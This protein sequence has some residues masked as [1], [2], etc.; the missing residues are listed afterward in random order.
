MTTALLAESVDTPALL[1]DLPRLRR[2]IQG[3]ASI[4][5]AAGINLRPHV[6]THKTLEIARLQREAGAVGLTV[7]KLAEAEV[8]ADAGFDDIFVAYP[9]IGSLKWSRAARLAQ[10]CRLTVGA[11]SS[12]GIQG[13]GRAATDRGAVIHVRVEFDSGLHRSGAGTSDLESLCRQVTET[14]GLR[15]D[16]IFTFR[17]SAF[18]GSAGRTA[19]ELGTEEGIL[20]ASLAEGLRASGIP[21]AA[22]SGGSTPT[23]A[24][25]ASTPG[26][27]EVRPGTYVFQDRMTLA[28]GACS[29]EDI[30]LTVLTT[31]VSR[32]SAD[33][34]IV[35]AGSKTLAAD[36]DPSSAGLQGYAAERQGRGYVEWLN[37]EHGA[38]R[39]RGDYQPVVGEA[40]ELIPNHVCTVV[41]LSPELVVVEDGTVLERWPVVAGLCRT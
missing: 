9:I 28:D 32:P 41:N 25:T 6:K 5:Q 21:I 16:G 20:L 11:E 33:I 19:A 40:M 35:D 34:A 17:S 39:L 2:N 3:F 13:L 8:F 29:A 36:V 38:V 23:G 14:P 15:L 26:V 10:R 1:V 27:S 30:A 22:V 4:T 18:D 7:A 31:V 24:A 12:T 37:E